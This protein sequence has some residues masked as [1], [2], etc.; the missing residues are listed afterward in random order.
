[1]SSRAIALFYFMKE[2][3]HKTL[4]CSLDIETS[5]FD[6]TNGEILELGMVF[7]EIE[8]H[9]LKVLSEWQSTFRPSREVSPRILALTG[10]TTEEL[11]VSPL[12]KDKHEEIQELV[13]DCVI[14]GHNIVFDIKF[15]ESFGI[16]FSGEK[17]DTLDLAQFILPTNQSYNLEA[18]MNL[19]EVSHK[20]A[21]R[22]LADAKAAMVVVEK[23][24]SFYST[25][26]KS[27][28]EKLLDLF[29]EKEFPHIHQLLN[30]EFEAREIVLKNKNVDTFTSKEI[31]EALKENKKVIT[32]PLGFDYYSYIFGAVQKSK[33]KILLVVGNKQTVYQLWKQK[34]AYP[35]FD[36]KEV[37]DKEAFEMALN[38][39]MTAEQR[40][41]FA[42]ILVWQ[43]TNWQSDILCDLN[44][45]F[46]GNQFRHLVNCYSKKEMS[47]PLEKSEK[48]VV[49][50]YNDFVNFDLEK[51]Y[52]DRKIV[53][54]DLNNFER[55]LTD[56]S[57]K[58]VSWNDFTYSLRQVYDPVTKNGKKEYE[59]LVSE[60]LS[61]V[62]LFF[63][64]ASMKWKKID[65][66]ATQL[67]VTEVVEQM[68]YFQAIDKA[69]KSFIE[70]IKNIN[71]ELDSERITD[72]LNCLESFFVPDKTQIKWI[73]IGE[74][75][76]LFAISPL[77]LEHIADKKLKAYKKILFTASLGSEALIKYFTHRLNVQDFDVQTIG[78][79]ELR[80]KFEVVI[81]KSVYDSS[82][83]LDLVQKMDT[84]AALLLPN[85]ATLKAFYEANF[86]LLGEKFKVSAQS[87][88]GGTNKLLDNFGHNENSL[89]IA[90][91]YFILKQHHRR[92]KVKS[93]ILTRIPF[94][95]FNHPLFAAQAERYP[96]QFI[97]FNIPRAL[98]NFHSLIRFFYSQD[99]EKIYLLD[100]KVHKEYGS[101][102]IDYLKSLPFV[103]ITYEN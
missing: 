67:L 81:P 100:Q 44:F 50:D 36:N 47:W 85:S 21:H 69:A 74:G 30:T 46:F 24:F 59:G 4:Y 92:L 26:P 17:I 40:F 23:L 2:K 77:S 94:E 99:L 7:F 68:E 3:N 52:S 65:T 80:K 84:P 88:S 9:G 102:F 103:E 72:H 63:G 6:A 53:I 45:S 57:S 58:K 90:T 101:F 25:F 5:D 98:Y 18:L 20:D 28:K 13:K 39:P 86:K 12:F 14:V 27:L 71:E 15:L 33:E 32:F 70:K 56:I 55:A 43:N 89:L 31:N 41:F 8:K 42:K 49:T 62:D 64:L 96:N 22:A 75:R 76:L 97:D 61:Q 54:L 51:V 91:D 1:M 48:V 29:D 34:L 79:Q 73:E 16:K 66:T 87:Y 60:A 10:I 38:G 11:E 83:I 82:K 93:L 35:V 19:L 37:F 78:Q 95:Q